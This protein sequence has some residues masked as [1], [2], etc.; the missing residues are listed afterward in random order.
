MYTNY[1][2]TFGPGNDLYIANNS[3]QNTSSGSAASTNYY[4]VP[5]GY[6]SLTGQS[7]FQCKEIEV[8]QI[9]LQ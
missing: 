8:Y 3:N 1:G 7:Y 6:A 2:P 4:N 5:G 9:V